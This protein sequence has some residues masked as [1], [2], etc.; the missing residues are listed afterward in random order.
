[1]TYSD[2]VAQCP[3]HNS[4]FEVCSGKNLDRA[5]GFAGRAT[6]QWSHKLLAMGRK[7]RDL[8]TFPTDLRDAE[9]FVTIQT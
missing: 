9:V 8:T 7:P 5:A 4:R 6:P 3:W 1:V 2:G